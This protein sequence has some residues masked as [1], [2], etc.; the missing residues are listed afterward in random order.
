[1]DYNQCAIH[2]I[3]YDDKEEDDDIERFLSEY[4]LNIDECDYMY[5]E[6]KLNVERIYKVNNNVTD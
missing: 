1:M 3:K 2:E 6:N 4:G 5:S